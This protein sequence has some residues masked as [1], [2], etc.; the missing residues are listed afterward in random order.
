MEN[1]VFRKESLDRISS[2]DEMHDYM[3]VTSPGLW[4]LLSVILALII[5][6]VVFACFVTI[7]ND[8]E[9][10]ANVVR[11]DEVGL[12]IVDIDIEIPDGFGEIVH[13]GTEVMIG[14][15][16]GKITAVYEDAAHGR[17]GR[18][19]LDDPTVLF[20][21]GTYDAKIILETISP[22]RFLIR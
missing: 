6:F 13:I 1:K 7:E 19:E 8:I 20:K 10:Q 14:E 17:G 2:P 11:Y 9:T 22:I 15:E 4:M 5:G 18:V 16:K 21:E 12:P 3:R